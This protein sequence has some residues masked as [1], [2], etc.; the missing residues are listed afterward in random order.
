MAALAEAGCTTERHLLR[1]FLEHARVSPLQYLQAIRLE[2]ARQALE[3]GASV[4]ERP[5]LPGSVQR[6]RC[7]ER[8]AGNGEDRR[9]MS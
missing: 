9:G 1:L 6:F 7:G 3:Y 4:T 8:G 2:R 5:S